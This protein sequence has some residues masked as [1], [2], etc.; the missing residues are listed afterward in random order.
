MFFDDRDETFQFLERLHSQTDSFLGWQ[1]SSGIGRIAVVLP[2][3]DEDL[4]LELADLKIFLF[5]KHKRGHSFLIKIV[6]SHKFF[7]FV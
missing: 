2:N 4:P 3:I 7:T 6:R 1:L 5:R